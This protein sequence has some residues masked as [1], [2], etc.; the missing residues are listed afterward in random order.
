MLGSS[1][2]FNNNNNLFTINQQP[3]PGLD[4]YLTLS[5]GNVI[6]SNMVANNENFEKIKK[7]QDLLKKYDIK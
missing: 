1:R 7:V 3:A 5:D 6:M 2:D 4:K